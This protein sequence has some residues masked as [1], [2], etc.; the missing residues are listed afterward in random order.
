MVQCR[1]Q[2][3]EGLLA[4]ERPDDLD[5]QPFLDFYSLSFFSFLF[6]FSFFLCFVFWCFL[7]LELCL[8]AVRLVRPASLRFTKQTL[9]WMEALIELEGEVC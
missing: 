7:E 8:V 6:F 1:L 9:G 4:G 3:R 5:D 2:S